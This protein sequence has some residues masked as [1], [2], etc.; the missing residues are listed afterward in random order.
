MFNSRFWCKGSAGIDAFCQ[1][2]GVD[3]N[4]FCPPV[5]LIPQV[6]KRMALCKAIGTLLVPKWPSSSFWPFICP[7]GLHFSAYVH[8]WRLL[9]VSFTPP[10]L[11]DSTVFCENP[12]FLSLAL[13]FNFR[14]PPRKTSRGFCSAELGYCA[15]CI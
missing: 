5:S 9:S 12:S 3:N 10:S 2:C 4:Y 11:G 1:D 6:I 8:D 13:R 14:I 7:D 15:E